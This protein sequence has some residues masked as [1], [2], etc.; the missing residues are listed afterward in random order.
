MR[1]PSI[2]RLA[3][4]GFSL[5]EILMGIAVLS[6]IGSVA[7]Y[8]I[9]TMMPSTKDGKLRRD[10][11]TLN[12]AFQVYEANGGDLSDLDAQGALDKLK[13]KASS[14]S[15]KQLAGLAG[16][17]VDN[18]LAVA[19]Q[20]PQEASTDRPRAY[21]NSSTKRF[22]IRTTG[23]GIREFVLNESI[24]NRDYGEEVRTST[25][26]LASRDKWIW[27]FDPSNPSAPP[28]PTERGTS[29]GTTPSDPGDPGNTVKLSPP[30]FSR[31]AGSYPL[32]DYP[33]SVTLSHP[34]SASIAEINYSLTSGVVQPY[35]GSAIS[36]DP[37]TAPMAYCR[38]LDPDRFDDSDPVARAYTTNA[39][40]MRMNIAFPKTSYTY[41]EMGG[42]LEPGAYT[43]GTTAVAGS[44][45][46]VNGSDI[47][48]AY[49]NSTT[50]TARWTTDGTD[51]L[52]SG[53]SAS[54]PAFSNGF[55]AQS[56]PVTFAQFGTGTAVDVKGGF[57]SLKPAIVSDSSVETVRLTA[58]VSTLRT[59]LVTTNDRD[60]TLALDVN[61]GDMPL[62]SYIYYTLDGTDPGNSSGE[63][64]R[65]TRY[66]LPLYL[67]G[68]TGST[69]RIIARAYPPVSY[70]QWFNPS[71]PSDTSY[72]LP[73]AGDVYV[74][75]DFYL[76][77]GASGVM[78][79]VAR[80]GAAGSVDTRFNT[81]TGA[82]A[83]S[84]VGVVRQGTG[85]V[86]AGGDFDSMNGTARSAIVR[87][88]PDGSVDPGFNA[89]LGGSGG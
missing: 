86:F 12:R 65:G 30:E 15:A 36:V 51:P 43:P 72:V 68:L 47:P 25:K 56:I 22:E 31:A 20:T 27:D 6:T 52:T 81:G 70:K 26:K 32:K 28:T 41:V 60:V 7:I 50:F 59:P 14:E 82:S 53:T 24:A 80:L 69:V 40:V 83:D 3:I 78:R 37:G 54:S 38:S 9:S 71:S 44:A 46:L 85:G 58:A 10:V 4:R 66:T 29:P 18:R 76:P 45:T 62:G 64:Q 11:A 33:L 75:G 74:G 1:T 17:M 63:P 87:L 55:P 61:Q 23:E 73:V 49:Q 16:R 21:W 34:N 48:L 79:N 8:G 84:L 89:A 88:L 57:R 77:S 19:L 42:P 39:V 2:S 5:V 67:D 35:G 13:R